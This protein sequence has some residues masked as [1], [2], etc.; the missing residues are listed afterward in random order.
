MA[1][2][3][4]MEGKLLRLG[5]DCPKKRSNWLSGLIR[6]SSGE[7]VWISGIADA[8]V[9]KRMLGKHPYEILEDEDER[10]VY[11]S[12]DA[13][14]KASKNGY[15]SW[16]TVPGS[17]I[18]VK[19]SGKAV[20]DFLSGNAFPHIGKATATK[21]WNAYYE[22]TY[23]WILQHPED[24]QQMLKCSDKIM[25][26]LA[27][28][29]ANH[30]GAS[31][32]QKAFPSISSTLSSQLLDYIE[33]WD[34]NAMKFVDAF[35][36]N[37]YR[38]LY[39]ISGLSFKDVDAVALADCGISIGDS[40]RMVYMV[41]AALCDALEKHHLTYIR[42]DISIQVG[43][44]WEKLDEFG[45]PDGYT[46][47]DWKHE[48]EKKDPA[49]DEYRFADVAVLVEARED[50]N[51]QLLYDVRT[52]RNQETI[53]EGICNGICKE[54]NASLQC[55]LSPVSGM[56]P[57]EARQALRRYMR[58]LKVSGNWR[59]TKRQ[60]EAVHMVF[61]HR[62]SCLTGGPGRGKTWTIGLICKSWNAVYGKN[63]LGKYEPRVI[64][65]APT[66]RAASR[67]EN[68]TGSQHYGTIARFIKRNEWS[69][70]S[71][72]KT[73]SI[74]DDKV[75]FPD[76]PTTLIIVDE[77]SMVGY[78]DI[79]AL[80]RLAPNCTFLFA[81]DADQLP[82]IALGPF[83]MELLH[84]P[85]VATVR[86]EEN[87][88]TD[89]EQLIRFFDSICRS[90][91]TDQEQMQVTSC[92]VDQINWNMNAE[93]SLP[94]VVNQLIWKNAGTCAAQN[95]FFLYQAVET[96]A[97]LVTKLHFSHAD[98][99]F[100][101]P[102]RKDDQP[103]PSNLINRILRKRLNPEFKGKAIEKHDRGG[104]SAR[105]YYDQ[106]GYTV[107][108]WKVSGEPVRIGD[109][110]MCTK[111]N[112]DMAWSVRAYDDPDGGFIKSGYGVYNGDRGTIIRY[113]PDGYTEDEQVEHGY[114]LVRLDNG[115]YI[116]L[117]HGYLSN[118]IFGYAVSVH[119]AQGSEAKVVL[120]VLPIR[121][122]D[123]SNSKQKD[124]QK[125]EV[126]YTKNLIYT[127]V[128]RAKQHVILLGNGEEFSGCMQCCF[129]PRNA[130]LA[131]D[132]Q[133]DL[134]EKG[135]DA[136]LDAGVSGEVVSHG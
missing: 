14:E 122:Y 101:S 69:F 13:E 82:P 5:A 94:P 97:Y 48:M 103:V 32:L 26:T 12:L 64:C 55:I 118:F 91:P 19:P 38:Y 23:D 114:L 36:Q 104:T 2:G 59:A 136:P 95:A 71:G 79:A 76:D 47:E 129:K 31:V 10:S 96:Y 66:G 43:Y 39:E 115:H 49:T 87:Q 62:I 109:R 107:R 29:V 119:K 28:G 78:E 35:R 86:L 125:E 105:T 98:I 46:F 61:D 84:V 90:L 134:K 77:S 131:L 34:I 53:R 99:L 89:E 51:V 74:S 88:R 6:L 3:V 126:F 121:T 30:M 120:F 112:A 57:L 73:P 132:L 116:T 58:S 21:L 133:L 24:V 11:V 63:V 93:V 72:L 40:R 113:Y 52:Y 106:E 17:L 60:E 16:R 100:M 56:T 117:L 4:H 110:I 92:P 15:I 20:I 22:N 18:H 33:L 85:Q 45:L 7:T 42:W 123:H 8:P 41:G 108:D 127:A 27:D 54:Q 65:L 135:I 124:R 80:F 50:P 83:F 128:T 70:G 75:V 37:P 67:L 68:E 25:Q 102:F 44:V 111:N 81:G 130:R 1:D 9:T